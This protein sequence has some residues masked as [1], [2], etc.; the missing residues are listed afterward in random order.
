MILT[1]ALEEEGLEIFA[2]VT[3][4]WSSE[5]RLLPHRNVLDNVA[6]GWRSRECRGKSKA[7]DAIELWALRDRMAA[8]HPKGE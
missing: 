8:F 7:R 3:S 1:F 5:L 2:D 4:A 6:L